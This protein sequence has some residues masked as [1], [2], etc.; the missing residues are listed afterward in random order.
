MNSY[1][2]IGFWCFFCQIWPSNS[3]FEVS[4]RW[5]HLLYS[6][7]VKL[8]INEMIWVVLIIWGEN[9]YG[10]TK[11]LKWFPKMLLKRQYGFSRWAWIMRLFRN[12]WK[13]SFNVGCFNAKYSLR[14]YVKGMLQ[15]YNCISLPLLTVCLTEIKRLIYNCAIIHHHSA[16]I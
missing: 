8:E 3:E 5:N 12:E 11:F 13:C 14:G 7:I 15:S 2:W 9:H 1:F 10:S 4:I 6:R 16:S